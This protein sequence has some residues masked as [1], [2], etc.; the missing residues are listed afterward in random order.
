MASLET[1]IL[2]V[3]SHLNQVAKET[4]DAE[5]L[6]QIIEHLVRG[7]KDAHDRIEHLER[8][9]HPSDQRSSSQDAT[10][11]SSGQPKGFWRREG[12]SRVAPR[13]ML[14]WGS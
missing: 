12:W 1:E 6:V 9:L 4:P 14:R 8:T 5:K 13:L 7:L 10:W 11:C 2:R 3:K